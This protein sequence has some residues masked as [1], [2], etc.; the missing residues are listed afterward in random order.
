MPDMTSLH[1]LIGRATD[2]FT[3]QVIN[4]PVSAGSIPCAASSVTTWVN[5][6]TLMDNR[7]LNAVEGELFF[8][9]W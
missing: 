4:G 3:S 7:R 5:Q 6:P 1:H 8:N 9:S 2:L